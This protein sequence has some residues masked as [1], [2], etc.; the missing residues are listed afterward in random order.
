MGV[1]QG[2]HPRPGGRGRGERRRGDP[3]NTHFG[4]IFLCF[5]RILV[6]PLWLLRAIFRGRRL[7]RAWPTMVAR[8]LLRPFYAG[9]KAGGIPDGAY[10]T[11]KATWEELVERGRR[12]AEDGQKEVELKVDRSEEQTRTE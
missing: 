11:V 6:R 4:C 3:A 2:A 8:C 5:G 12:M 9:R 10:T 1:R 7:R